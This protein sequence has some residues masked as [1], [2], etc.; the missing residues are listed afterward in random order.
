ME[1]LRSWLSECEEKHGLC[2]GII[3]GGLLT[4]PDDQVL[5]TRI[6]D[7]LGKNESGIPHLL[8]TSG[9]IRGR[10]VALSHCW[11]DPDHRPLTT[12][13]A[14]LSA[15]LD[16]IPLAQ[17]PRTFQDA[18]TITRAIGV[19]Y[20]WIDSLCIVQDDKDDWWREAKTMGLVYE[21]A[22]LTIAASGA[23][24][25]R[26]GCFQ[27]KWF[28][29]F[30]RPDVRIPF[31]KPGR[32]ANLL[33][34]RGVITLNL[35]WRVNQWSEVE[36]LNCPLSFRG[37][38]TQ[39]WILSRK[40]VHFLPGGMIWSC[41]TRS[42]D[43]ADELMDTG[44]YH[45]TWNGKIDW[46]NVATSHSGRL[47]T[48][49]SDKLVSLEGL[50]TEL[51]KKKNDRCHFGL[52]AG[53]LQRQL[54][55][56]PV[57]ILPDTDNS[58]VPSWSWASRRGRIVYKSSSWVILRN[59]FELESIEDTGRLCIK[60]L[61]ISVPKMSLHLYENDNLGCPVSPGETL[62]EFFNNYDFPVRKEVM[63]IHLLL[64][65][66]ETQIGHACLD[67]GSFQEADEIFFAAICH[68]K[69]NWLRRWDMQRRNDIE[70]HGLLIKRIGES[71]EYKRVGVGG[72][73][74]FDDETGGWLNQIQPKRIC[75][76]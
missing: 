4:D 73:L 44:A 69:W 34:R 42:V 29:R 66:N 49:W 38:I 20:L 71:D 41:S 65:K 46:Y 13:R 14:T 19:R 64:D 53:E 50:A 7:V 36:L 8:E 15:R 25:S 63:G 30:K 27:D 51:E 60:T 70:Y 56:I 6:L 75:I 10:F 54:L 58:H 59:G 55:W 39:E 37:W 48:R 2:T 1:L 68:G 74:A 28:E 57:G 21:Q 35:E 76:I 23:L 72:I 32:F 9:K 12:T 3:S 67:D 47:F 5:P 11:G 17:L 62:E 61:C 24:D 22:T 40:L 45:S 16:A 43:E 31:Y 52:W 18:I 26:A 33:W